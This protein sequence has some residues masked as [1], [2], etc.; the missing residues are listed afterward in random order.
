MKTTKKLSRDKKGV[1]TLFISI[2]I[3]LLATMLIS[4]IF[5]GISLSGS[6]LIES[7]RGEQERIQESILIS[8]PDGMKLLPDFATVE[9]LRVQ[10]TGSISVQIKALYIGQNFICDPS[11]A[12]DTTIA[13]GEEKW[14]NLLFTNP[15]LPITLDDFA[16]ENLWKVTTARGTTSSETGS[17]ILFDPTKPTSPQEF[18]IGPFMIF[19]DM[20]NWKSGNGP[21]ESGWTIPKGI[22]TLPGACL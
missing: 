9:S 22:V 14:I 1:S 13:P 10:N 4:T 11:L 15:N 6:G 12:E 17:N 16:L 7:L 2:Y 19:F 8:G 3:A 5:V 21:W 20:F 18:Y